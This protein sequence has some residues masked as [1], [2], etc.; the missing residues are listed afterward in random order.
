[1]VLKRERMTHAAGYAD[2][3][4]GVA[5]AVSGSAGCEL[6]L[7]KAVDC[8]LIENGT[9]GHLVGCKCFG[10]NGSKAWFDR[11]GAMGRVSH[12]GWRSEKLGPVV[13]AALP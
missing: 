12:G 11:A 4:P 10:I 5:I 8:V 2:H 6:A 9:I 13:S 7:G 3:R 1:M